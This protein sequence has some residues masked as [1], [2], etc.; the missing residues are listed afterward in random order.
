MLTSVG[1]LPD[2]VANLQVNTLADGA[3]HAATY[4]FTAGGLL[5]LWR[6]LPCCVVAGQ[7]GIC[8]GR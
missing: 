2:S 3:F 5:V 4:V 1:Y 8:W 6:A 7:D